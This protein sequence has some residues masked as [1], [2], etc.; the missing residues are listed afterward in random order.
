M[1]HLANKSCIQLIRGLCVIVKKV[2]TFYLIVL[3][4]YCCF[5]YEWKNTVNNK[6]I[7]E[8]KHVTFFLKEMEVLY[9]RVYPP[10][11]DPP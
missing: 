6:V 9:L 4:Y 7:S 5:L 11:S 2:I 3:K 1:L 8:K 10:S